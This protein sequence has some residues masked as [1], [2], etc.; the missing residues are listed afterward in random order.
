MPGHLLS[1]GQKAGI[2]VTVLERA[3]SGR[4]SPESANWL[5]DNQSLK[6]HTLL[7]LQAGLWATATQL[8]FEEAL[9]AVVNAGGDTDPNGVLAGAVLGARHGATAVPLRWTTRIAQK[10]RLAGLGERLLT[11]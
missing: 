3:A 10:E 7:T 2:D 1:A 5:R 6:G 4:P 11:A 8:G 9:A